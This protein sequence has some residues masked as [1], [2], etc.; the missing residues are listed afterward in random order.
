QGIWGELVNLFFDDILEFMPLFSLIIA[1]AV[2][3]SL[4]STARPKMKKN[5]IGDIIHFVCYG[6][7]IVLVMSTIISMIQ[8]TSNTIFSI[9][10]QTDATFPILLT[11]LTAVGATTSSTVFQ[12]S[13]ALLGGTIMN[14]FSNILMPLFI[15]RLVFSIISNLTTNVKFEKFA[16]LFSSAFKWIIGFVFTIFSG[17]MAIQGI[18][19]GS[20][21]SVSIRATKYAVKSS[22]PILGGYISDG[23]NLI[24]SSSILIKNAVG[25][26][27]LFLMAAVVVIP[28]LKLV[29][30]M[31][32]L[33]L[34]SAVLEP[35]TDNRI[36]NFISMVAKSV[37]L[38]I[39]IIVG[40]AFMY[41]FMTGLVI[42]AGNYF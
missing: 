37:S 39:V 28:V 8:L 12:P 38:L 33:K 19:A 11:M 36:S 42:G 24:L 16:D 23:L 25:V 13:V 14:V 7:I 6:S 22:I 9:K 30:L 29:V 35:L 20:F 27:G 17:F 31:F 21:D 26:A 3:Y 1:I 2:A 18:S 34:T 5:S 41:F 4:V 15:F 10:S 32:S 40:M